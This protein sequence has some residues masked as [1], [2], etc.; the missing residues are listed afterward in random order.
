M[1]TTAQPHETLHPIQIE[2]SKTLGRK[3]KDLEPF[4]KASQFFKLATDIDDLCEKDDDVWES[5]SEAAQMWVNKALKAHA[6][7]KGV[8]P[9]SE[10]IEKKVTPATK[11]KGGGAQ[12]AS[13]EVLKKQA[14]QMTA[15]EPVQS[16]KGYKGHK[17]GSKAELM[18]KL[19][20]QHDQAAA[21]AKAV[22]A[23]IKKTSAQVWIWEFKKK[24]SENA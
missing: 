4:T 16:G 10:E 24:D 18:R 23:G 7:K 5:L 20:D 11:Q 22:E 12:A 6:A 14:D 19:Y 21:I 9:F 15:P 8:P 3:K 1:T 13:K 17:P 2:L